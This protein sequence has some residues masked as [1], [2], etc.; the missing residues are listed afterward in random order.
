MRLKLTVT[1]PPQSFTE[2]LT[3]SDCQDFLEI[4]SADT[5]RQ[6]LVESYIVAA[7]E[8]AELRQGRDLVNKQYDLTLDRWPYIIQLREG[9]TTVDI[10]RYKGS[11]GV[12]VTMVD[13]TDYIFDTDGYRLTP[14]YNETWPWAS[15]WPTSPIFVRYTVEALPPDAQVL[16]GM[17]YL[18]SQWYNNRIPAEAGASRIVEYPYALGLLDHGKVERP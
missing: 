5:T 10:F 4:P 7:R 18:I 2:P 6:T 13:G 12:N 11:D 17:K 14:P 3:Y 8:V 15:L 9:A 16:L 1:S